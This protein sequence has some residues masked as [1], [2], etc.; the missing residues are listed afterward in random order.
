MESVNFDKYNFS[1]LVFTFKKNHVRIM[2][3]YFERGILMYKIKLYATDGTL[4]KSFAVHSPF[5][6]EK[7]I[8]ELIKSSA[9]LIGR[10][11]KLA[12]LVE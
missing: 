7:R 1:I 4:K 3:L 6:F 8:G 9:L 10:N 11:D 5:R 2:L 12:E